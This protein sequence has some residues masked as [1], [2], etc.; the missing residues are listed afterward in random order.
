V[1]LRRWADARGFVGVLDV[2]TLGVDSKHIDE[3]GGV[4]DF[5]AAGQS[6]TEEV[7]NSE[8]EMQLRHPLE[9]VEQGTILLPKNHKYAEILKRALALHGARSFDIVD[10]REQLEPRKVNE[11]VINMLQKFTAAVI[12][13]D[14]YGL[15]LS[16]AEAVVYL[17]QRIAEEFSAKVTA[18][19][20]DLIERLRQRMTTMATTFALEI[21]EYPDELV[22]GDCPAV[23]MS[24]DTN[25]AG[26]R[27]GV[28][29]QSADALAMPVG[30]HHAIALGQTDRTV[31][32][33]ALDTVFLNRRSIEAAYRE[34]FFRGGSGLGERIAR[35][36]GP[37]QLPRVTS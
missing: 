24:K 29:W 33:T 34:V 4:Q 28:G 21:N 3:S 16:E 19:L 31:P 35:E 7:W 26:R 36:A 18:D 15:A 37:Q 10:M 14:Q 20:P 25:A 1:L 2:S 22:L 5:L 12:V 9:L 17:R 8:V 30:P 32:R 23:A 11:I 6:A 27:N 13:E